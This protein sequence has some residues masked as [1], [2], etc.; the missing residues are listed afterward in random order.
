MNATLLTRGDI[1]VDDATR[2]AAASALTT[3][4]DETIERIT[5]HT[6]T[7]RS[8]SVDPALAKLIAKVVAR[9]AQGG[10]VNVATLPERLTTSAAADLLGVS[11]TTVM[12]LIASGELT[13]TKA[14]S[15]HRL[16]HGDV[17]ALKHRREQNRAAVL[18]E[19]LL[20]ED[21]A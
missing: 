13:S 11:R 9:V 6:E 4:G 20:F 19:L 18:E 21:D 17:L 16:R 15:H 3:A 7:G 8:L 1:V 14:G 5:F 12:K 10:Q 2:R